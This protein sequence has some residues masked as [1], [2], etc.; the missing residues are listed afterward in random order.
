MVLYGYQW[1][2]GQFEISESQAQVICLAFTRYQEGVSAEVIAT[3]LNQEGYRS[4]FSGKIDPSI[5]CRVLENER[6]MGC[7]M[8]QK[9]LSPQLALI[10]NNA[11]QAN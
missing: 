5:I 8:L 6:D 4:Y 11:T 2:D 9:L 10:K 7:Q 1:A 3:R